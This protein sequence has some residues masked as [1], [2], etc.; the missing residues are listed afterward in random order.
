MNPAWIALPPLLPLAM[1][2]LNLLTWR[3]PRPGSRLAGRVSALVPARDEAEN[4]EACLR[5]LLAT[6]VD[7][8]LVCDDQSTDGTDAIVRRLAGE[9]PRLRLIQ[10]QGP[11]PGWL[12]KPAA[13]D[14]LARE[15][16]GDWLLFVDA[17]VRV[18]P[19]LLTRLGDAAADVDAVTAVPRQETGSL[20]ERLVIPLLHLTYLSWLP[21][22]LVAL[23]RSPRVLAANGQILLVRAGAYRAVGGYWPVRADVVD[24]MAFCRL[25]KVHGRRVRFLDGTTLATCRMYRDARATL[26]GFSKNLYPGIGATPLRLGV[27]LGL[28]AT[29]FLLPWLALPFA[30][31][32]ALAGIGA[33]LLQ[34][35]LLRARFQ[36][37]WLAVLGHVPSI[38]LFGVIALRSA[39]WAWGGRGR[40][41]GRR[42]SAPA[43]RLTLAERLA[44]AWLRWRIGRS[45]DGLWVHGWAHLEAAARRGPVLVASNHVGWWDGPVV[46]AAGMASKLRIHLV[47]EAATLR[48]MP[49]L[50]ALGVLPLERG[51]AGVASIRRLAATLDGPGRVL[52]YFP[53]GRQR[54]PGIRPL[55]FDPRLARI[56]KIK[57][58]T[59]LPAALAYPFRDLHLPAAALALGEPVTLEGAE[60]ATEALL[61][62]ID[63]WAD[64]ADPLGFAP[65]EAPRLHPPHHGLGARLLGGARPLVTS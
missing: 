65:A 3:P 61:D 19:D 13:C 53:Q 45:L 9:D 29:C 33:N 55:G 7:E 54:P 59:L 49:W 32:A 44:G 1:T 20:V 15:A 26:D 21:L 27:V 8:I 30:P 62:R 24:D 36:H 12:G 60:A 46:L 37:P 11:P 41:R 17:D 52:W 51:P 31:E 34:R 16:T 5:T 10:G 35:L 56:A 14:A 23:L 58:A 64:G 43:F 40:W 39:I 38:L 50:R 4:I 47:A 63:R 28:Y 2:A 48:R 6:E 42:T 22:A 18:E 25:L 57:G